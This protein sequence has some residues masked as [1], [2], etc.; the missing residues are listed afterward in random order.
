MTAPQRP[1]G[2]SH[3]TLGETVVA[4]RL[5]VRPLR[6]L[7][8][9]QLALVVLCIAT[10]VIVLDAS[11]V[12]VALP[13]IQD[14][15]GF[16]QSNLAWVVNAYLI[17]FGGLLLFAGRLG[18]L[19]GTRRV[20]VGGLALFTAASVACGFAQ[21]QAML[22]AARFAQGVGGALA[23]AVVLGMIITMFPKPREQARALGFYSFVAA[24][25]AAFGLLVGALLTEALNWHWIF[26]V[27]VPIGLLTA[28]F[29]L[30]LLD[31]VRDTRERGADVLGTVLIVGSLMLAVY[32][33]VQAV[34]HGWKSGRTLGLAGLAVVLMLAFS[35][36]QTRA[37]HP[38]VPSIVLRTR[39][40]AWANVVVTL[41]VAGPAG[42]FFL[43]A[44]YLQ[45]VLHF[46]VIEIG[47][48]FIPAAAAIAIVSLKV[49][50]RLMRHI[51]AKTVLLP[52]LASMVAGLA[53]FARAP[54]DGHYVMDILPPMLLVGI[55]AGLGVPALLTVAL[56]D[57]TISDSGVRSGLVNTT[58]QIGAALGLAVLA[59]VSTSVTTRRLGEGRPIDAALTSGFQVAF[60]VGA[61][62]ALLALLLAATVV[63]PAVPETAPPEL[64]PTAHVAATV[65][66]D[67]TD[68]TGA[69]NADFLALGL[70]GTNMMSMLWTIA[71]G[72]RAVGVE[73]RGDP[74]V[75]VMHWNIRED[76]YHHL[77]IIDGLMAE[78]YGPDRIPRRGD[79]SPFLLHE[80]F[81]LHDEDSDGD[82]NA[83]EVISGWAGDSHIGG[84]VQSLE[85]I[86]DRWVDGR[87][88][89]SVTS[90]GPADVEMADLGP[91]HGR[92]W[93]G[94]SIADVLD[95]RPRFQLSA[96][97]IQILLR[98]YLAELERMD[99][100]GG[101]EPRC[102]MFLYHRAVDTSG[103]GA[104]KRWLRGS[105]KRRQDEEGFVRLPDGRLQV[106]IEALRELD[107]KP[108]YR[109]I[110]KPGS[111]I[112]DLGVPELIMIAE[113]I[114]STDAKRLGFTQE[115]VKI[116]HHDGRGPV[117]AQ[118]DYLLGLI[119]MYIGS[120]CRRRIASEFDKDGNEYWVR[121]F[122]I[123][124]EYDAEIGWVLVE[125][126][127]FKTFD[128][129][130]AGLVPPGTSRESV[131]YFG[132]YQHLTREFYLKQ[133][134]LLTEISLP[135]LFRTSLY[136][137]K[138][139][140]VVEKVGVDALV[141]AN[142]VI[143]G[144]SFGTGHML[145][146]GGINTGVI[147]HASRVLQYWQARY[148][149]IAPAAAIRELAD[150]IKQDT[151]D[152]VA[153]SEPDFQQPAPGRVRD[154]TAQASGPK[155]RDRTAH[156]AVLDSTR[157]H[158]RSIAPIHHRDD[159]S[160]LQ[161]Y[162]GRLHT[163]GPS[164]I[165]PTHPALR[166]EA[167]V[168]T[169]FGQPVGVPTGVP[170]GAPVPPPVA[171][172]PQPWDRGMPAQGMP[173]QGMP[174]QGMPEHRLPDQ[175]VPGWSDPAVPNWPDQAEPAWQVP[176]PVPQ[177]AE[178]AGSGRAGSGRA[179][180]R[181][182]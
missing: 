5:E 33:I 129:I 145:T 162:V 182:G 49:T 122:G 119:T 67:V 36:W 3:G 147:G 144:D 113:G 24:S 77:A 75:A 134:S 13:S 78:R 178:L 180:Q 65:E 181:F 40:V 72:R 6:N 110:R 174:A 164:P 117:V 140:S 53:L 161:V 63:K 9:R 111:A 85:S 143:A 152:W 95:S 35:W 57:S 125:V 107:E 28:F 169:P 92:A 120:R 127:D 148:A 167:P 168:P 132:A 109:R 141:A 94:R 165:Q 7:R 142:C 43:G 157:Q 56:A 96:E 146:S 171:A 10:L 89:R 51:D 52:G 115:T 101:Y 97:D 48:A 173:A 42:M 103:G 118:A 150:G 15:L 158:R 139:I 58:Q 4:R 47:M 29:A 16:S 32:T 70:G 123:G 31:E 25:G 45:Q 11:V 108:H 160:R 84:L 73:L 17:P 149:G 66:S 163:H 87:P 170:V 131:E 153:V 59:T 22:I 154:Y 130:V 41:M 80:T 8:E 12:N 34:E 112:V 54:V 83:D 175:A 88:V 82:A 99:L 91:E 20:F 128:P 76:F 172:G 98:R 179:P 114:E 68:L 14:G 71:M 156:Y 90:V 137:P 106:R 55:G 23:S 136:T 39:N 155:H 86:D 126:P 135:Q 176:G 74:T 104:T 30:R 61:G 93:L 133:V 69:V 177:E 138:L 38:L 102:R 2:D 121:Q 27:N 26:F 37:R 159:W 50:P 46:K 124:H 64:D 1:K 116:D 105:R 62:I 81:Y 166:A 44:L 151:S 19:I 79:G 100:A 18:D 60:L 21:T